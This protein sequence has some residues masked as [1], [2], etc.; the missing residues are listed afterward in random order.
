M[1]RAS[2]LVRSGD[3]EAAKTECKNKLQTQERVAKSG[4]QKKTRVKATREKQKAKR[5]TQQAKSKVK[6]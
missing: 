5:G 1:H 2:A 6:S 3:P 4:E